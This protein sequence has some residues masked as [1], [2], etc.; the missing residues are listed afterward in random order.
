MNLATIHPGDRIE[1]NVRGV[2]FTARVLDK[3][4]DL[5]KIEPEEKWATW[6]SLSARAVVRKVERA[7]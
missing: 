6:R 1:A 4:R 3:D 7:T 5:L 2:R